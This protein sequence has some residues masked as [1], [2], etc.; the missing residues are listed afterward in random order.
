MKIFF[1]VLGRIIPVIVSFLILAAH[2]QRINMYLFS[3]VVLLVLFILFYTKPISVRVIQGIL[4]LGSLEWIRS[5]F[6]Y[7][8][9][10]IEYGEPWIR[11][12]VILGAVALFTLA[13]TIVF[14]NKKLR[15]VYGME[16]T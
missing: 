1:K 15:E 16:T 3:Y 4:I 7:S 6:V 2:F 9:K 12:A 13:S 14:R 10:R 5:I 8:A 11:L